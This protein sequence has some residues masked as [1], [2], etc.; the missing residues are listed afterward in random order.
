MY[1]LFIIVEHVLCGVAMVNIPIHYQNT[2]E[3]ETV[4][5]NVALF[6]LP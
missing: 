5:Q 3:R 4:E 2:A 6:I 1:I